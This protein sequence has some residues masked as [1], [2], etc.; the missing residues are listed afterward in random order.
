MPS[1]GKTIRLS[2]AVMKA[3]WIQKK[4]TIRKECNKLDSRRCE[5]HGRAFF[6]LFLGLA[7]LAVEWEQERKG[8]RES[9]PW[10]QPGEP[11]PDHRRKPGVEECH[12]GAP[13]EG[14]SQIRW[15]GSAVRRARARAVAKLAESLHAS[16]LTAGCAYRVDA[17][18]IERQDG[19]TMVAFSMCTWFADD[20]C[21]VTNDNI[22]VTHA[23]K[24]YE[25]TMAQ[26]MDL[27]ESYHGTKQ[28]FCF[29][30]ASE[31]PDL[32]DVEIGFLDL[33]A[34]SSSASSIK[35]RPASIR[36]H[37]DPQNDGEAQAG[38][39]LPPTVCPC[40]PWRQ[41][42]R[43]RC[44]VEHLQHQHTEAKRFCR[45]GTKQ[46][47]VVVAL[48]D[49]DR[50]HD[51]TPQPT[52]LARASELLRK[53]VKGNMPR[54]RSFIDKSLRCVFHSDGPEFVNIRS[55]TEATGL[56]GVDNLFYDRGFADAFLNAAAAH[57]ASLHKIQAYFLEK[58]RR[59]D[60][61]LVSV[62]PRGN[63]GFW[64]N[65]LEDLEAYTARLMGRCAAIIPED[66]AA[67]RTMTRRG[68]TGATL[69]LRGIGSE[70]SRILARRTAWA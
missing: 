63:N 35:K 20:A 31:D 67:N 11:A 9:Q 15:K 1:D 14:E 22:L 44:L 56:R 57:H 21:V 5:N 33:L 47:R 53:T 23:G 61:K 52:F 7:T 69:A 51:R 26:L 45:A 64:M 40:C 19:E 10:I 34:G 17:C 42:E 16:D 58:C 39:L 66:E 49:H 59:D 36:Q 3:K 25:G 13:T 28:T 70:K 43:C 46:L 6:F 65:V 37:Q 62:I 68:R 27:L 4:D 48:Y 38:N 24:V 60:G 32:D 41:F 29:D 8:V 2:L 12:E 18:E 55:I 54:N 50:L 30:I